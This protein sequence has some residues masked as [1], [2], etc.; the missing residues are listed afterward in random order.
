[1]PQNINYDPVGFDFE[2]AVRVSASDFKDAIS[3][4]TELE[5]T[6]SLHVNNGAVH[7]GTN[8]IRRRKHETHTIQCSVK[9]I[10]NDSESNIDVDTDVMQ[11]VLSSFDFVDDILL[12]VNDT[13]IVLRGELL[14]GIGVAVLIPAVS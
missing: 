6:A 4:C 3:I 11:T 10:S 14:D 12:N 1:M 2:E 5:A 8:I 13:D 9:C 7:I